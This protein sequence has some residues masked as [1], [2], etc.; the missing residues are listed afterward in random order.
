MISN[1]TDIL[2]YSKN[3]P[4]LFTR[5]YFWLFFLIVFAIFTLVHKKTR[6]R[7]TFLFFAS[8]YFYY[9]TSG[10]FFILLLFTA[11]FDYLN[12]KLIA[13]SDSKSKRKKLM[14]L[15]IVINL[16]ILGYFKYTY[17]FTDLFN[18]L[19]HSH[20]QARNA[21]SLFAN[22]LF[23]TSFDATKIILPIGISFYTFQSLSYII[24]LAKKRIP[25][26]TNFFDY[27]FYVSFFPQLVSGPITKASFFIPQL[28]N[29]FSLTKEDFDKAL[30]LIFTGLIK[31]LAIAD[32]ISLNFI[33]RVFDLPLSYTGF[34]N[35]M[36]MYAYGIQI[37][38]D[39]SGYT[40]IAIGIA[41]L[42]GFRLP[43]NFNSPYKAENITDFWKRWHI[44]LTNWFR[45]FVFTPL[46]FAVSARL[47]HEKY[48]WLKT[49]FIIYL[50]GGMVTFT[51]TG[52]WHGADLRF[53][54]WGGMHGLMLVG[55]RFWTLNI[56]K[57]LKKSKKQIFGHFLS[58]FITFNLITFAW[59]F[60]RASNMQEV[61][62]MLHQVFTSFGWKLIPDIVINYKVV[63]MVMIA[64]YTIHWL[65]QR[66]KDK[67]Y[68]LFYKTPQILKLLILLLIVFL[69]YQIKSSDIQPFIYFQF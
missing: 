32:Y 18:E 36:A 26:V 6:I 8:L 53:L 1:I 59:L 42:M 54:I 38:C 60:F 20:L 2:L 11:T 15:S 7:N 21:L 46:A 50:I 68:L 56:R 63:F 9:K 10:F 62:F 64:A 5:L 55:H 67:Y 57:K 33:D 43:I 66:F 17:F 47:K 4:L 48:L 49:D 52:L 12:G 51:L 61:R 40:D 3:S 19:F 45:D 30:L 37:Y 35:L 31:K 29:G 34:E 41:L 13:A 69:L 28:Y 39:F 58:V 44:S 25:V 22:S 14:W 23:G 16:S 65:P 24:D 27:C